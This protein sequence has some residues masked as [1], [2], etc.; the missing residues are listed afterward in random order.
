MQ[1]KILEKRIRRIIKES[2]A[3]PTVKFE[4][5]IDAS[6][7]PTNKVL[8]LITRDGSLAIGHFDGESFINV[9]TPY[10]RYEKVTIEHFTHFGTLIK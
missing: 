4:S 8:I 6:E 5:I 2:L 1:K 3:N 7:I 10:R 9:A